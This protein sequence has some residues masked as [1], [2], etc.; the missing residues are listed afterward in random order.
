MFISKPTALPWALLFA[1]NPAVVLVM[2]IWGSTET[3]S[4]FFI[5]GSILLAEKNRPVG[6]WLMLTAAAFTRPQMLVL[7][8]LLGAVFLRKFGVNRNL[9]A[10]SWTVIVAFIVM[11]PFALTISPSVPIDWIARTLIFHFGHGQPDL[12]YLVTSPGYYSVWPLPLLL[13]NAHPAFARLLP[14]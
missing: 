11:A 12:P 10:L 5:L 6:A 13:A 7:A 14:P 1:L 8:F 2:S 4:V 9:A 3:I